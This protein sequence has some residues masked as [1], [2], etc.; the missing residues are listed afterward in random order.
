MQILLVNLSSCILYKFLNNSSTFWSAFIH[1]TLNITPLSF[2]IIPYMITSPHNA[3]YP[4]LFHSG[5]I[6]PFR[7]F[8]IHGLTLK[9]YHLC[10]TLLYVP[11]TFTCTSKLWVIPTLLFQPLSHIHSQVP[12]VLQVLSIPTYTLSILSCCPAVPHYL[13]F[14]SHLL[15]TYFHTNSPTLSSATG[16]FSLES[17]TRDLSSTKSKQFISHA[18]TFHRPNPHSNT[19]AFTFHTTLSKNRINNHGDIKHSWNRCTFA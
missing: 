13:T 4:V 1:T 6:H 15:S 12:K 5:H 16:G 9:Y 3:Y 7:F 11:R 17:A 19:L 10:H 2:T 14:F 18:P 8:W